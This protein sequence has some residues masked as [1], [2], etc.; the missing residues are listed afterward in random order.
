MWFDQLRSRVQEHDR[1]SE[2]DIR[3]S[4][5]QALNEYNGYYSHTKQIQISSDGEKVVNLPSDWVS[6]YSRID[7]L[8]YPTSEDLLVSNPNGYPIPS[9]REISDYSVS[10]I[11]GVDKLFVM[12]DFPEGDYLRLYY[13]VPYTEDTIESIPTHHSAAVMNLST[14]YLLLKLAA[15]YSQSIHHELEAEAVDYKGRASDYL[16]QASWYRDKWE[17]IMGLGKYSG[18][19]YGQSE[20]GDEPASVSKVKEITI[21][22]KHRIFRPS[23]ER[24]ERIVY[25]PFV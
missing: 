6:R 3:E 16:K 4:I 5:L 12:F 2:E 10:T 19:S 15:I 14:C 22:R 24:E 8:E 18:D 11:S 20:F 25:H 17:Q 9:F 23:Y 13:Y 1:L 21:S 7:K